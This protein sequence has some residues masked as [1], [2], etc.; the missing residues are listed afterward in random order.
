MF[1]KWLNDHLD[2]N[3]ALHKFVTSAR[4]NLNVLVTYTCVL[5]II[6]VHSIRIH[7][8]G[9]LRVTGPSHL[10]NVYLCCVSNSCPLFQKKDRRKWKEGAV[11]VCETS[12]TSGVPGKYSFSICSCSLCLS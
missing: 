1:N 6:I 8:G 2:S 10:M 7:C 9:E 3:S 5:I 11:K 12:K 4:S